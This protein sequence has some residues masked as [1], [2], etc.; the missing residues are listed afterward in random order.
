MTIY[1]HSRLSCF[2]QCRL[3]FKYNYID[4]IKTGKVSVE[5][6][7]GNRFHEVMEYLY[8]EVKFREVLLAELNDLFEKKWAKNWNDNIYIVKKERTVEDYKKIGLSAIEDYYNHYKPFDGDKILG[9]ERE[10]VISLGD[11]NKYKLRCIIDRLVERKSG[12]YEIHDYKTSSFLPTQEILD[13]DI[14]LG[15][16]EIAVRKTWNDVNKIDLIWHYAMFDK[17]LRSSRTSDKLSVL[18]NE[19]IDLIKEVENCI[20]YEPSESNLCNWCE[21]KGICPLFVHEEKLSQLDENE[22][23]NDDGVKL[24]NEYVE[25][26]D[27]KKELL[28]QIN[29][30]ERK[31]NKLKSE[32]IKKAE[33]DC[34]K[35]FYGATKTATIKEDVK[36][37]Y[38]KSNEIK[39]VEFEKILNQIGIWNEI[40]S[41]SLNWTALK[42]LIKKG[43]WSKGIPDELK[44][45]IN[46]ESVKLVS[47]SNKK[48]D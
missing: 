27:A 33:K 36:I 19:T 10:L 21:Y 17:E 4:R 7:L 3:R 16:Y 44:N 29:N 24:V 38:P 37:D 18:E 41:N 30:I 11:D 42:N 23:L 6:F 2:K 46:I 32:I 28:D 12:D 34:V 5:A 9:L 35:R 15:L 26:D 14:Q 22:Y 1:S 48:I 47:F 39:R 31:Q 40:S 45:Y 20:N 43:D 25:L 13:K 8:S